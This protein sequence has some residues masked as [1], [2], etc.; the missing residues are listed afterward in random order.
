MSQ[1]TLMDTF[2]N[3]LR[4][5]SKGKELMLIGIA[6]I[7]LSNY[8]LPSNPMAFSP[9][10]ISLCLGIFTFAYGLAIRVVEKD[11]NPP[12]ATGVYAKKNR[13][14]KSKAKHTSRL[15]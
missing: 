13:K 8:L 10:N 7:I 3:L 9:T 15:T 1:S 14:A 5:K 4:G 2:I 6:L 12:H 11:R